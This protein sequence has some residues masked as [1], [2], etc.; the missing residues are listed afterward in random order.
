[1]P[2]VFAECVAPVGSWRAPETMTYHRTY[3]LPPPTTLVGLLGA[4][5]GLSLPDAYGWV[6][7]RGLK[8]GVGGGAGG[9]AKDLWKFQKLELVEK[10]KPPF[11]D[12]LLREWRTDVRL[13]LA[14]ECPD[15]ADAE[16]VAGWLRHPAYPL[17][18]GPSDLLMHAVRVW[19]ADTPPAETATPHH[20]LVPREVTPDYD[21]VGGWAAGPLARTVTAPSVERVPA[22]LRF[23][24]DDADR[25]LPGPRTP[26][27]F[28][29]DPVRL[30]GEAVTGYAVEPRSGPLKQFL[31]DRPATKGLPWVI[32]VALI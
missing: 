17:T 22:A 2:V 8:L 28:V 21:L 7:D 26:V 13:V 10:E 32:P 30:N 24:P 20:V 6:R 3:P 12:V 4:A 29:A 14:V 25:R 23:D 1:M 11:R 9:F 19:A 31:A 16:T 27:T 15:P 18:A 5:A